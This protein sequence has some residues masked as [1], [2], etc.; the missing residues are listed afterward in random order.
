[1]WVLP[2]LPMK[3][4]V[5]L[6]EH[7]KVQKNLCQIPCIIEVWISWIIFAHLC[8]HLGNAQA[9]GLFS[10]VCTE[11]SRWLGVRKLSI[12]FFAFNLTCWSWRTTFPKRVCAWSTTH[13]P[14]SMRN[15]PMVERG[16]SLEALGVWTC[17]LYYKGISKISGYHAETKRNDSIFFFGAQ[18]PA[19]ILEKQ[20]AVRVLAT[21][22]LPTSIL[23]ISFIC[24]CSLVPSYMMD[25]KGSDF[26]Y[27][28]CPIMQHHVHF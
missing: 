18:R 4:H 25:T 5:F 10:A 9:A 16:H 3:T 28:A 20:A 17:G 6:K 11:A 23:N 24:V 7:P 13:I 8:P 1:M 15:I 2:C 27:L 14:F 19:L 26:S 21:W 12:S 22:S